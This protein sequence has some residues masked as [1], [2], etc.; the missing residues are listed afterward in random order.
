ME[1]NKYYI[2]EISEFFVGFEYEMLNKDIWEQHTIS[3]S[4]TLSYF[5]FRLQ[6]STLNS[7][8]R[9]KYLDKYDIESLGWIDISNEDSPFDLK[10]YTYKTY[11]LIRDNLTNIKIFKMDLNKDFRGELFQGTIK[12][13]SE[14]RKLLKQIG[15][16]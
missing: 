7:V 5:M 16:E 9:V 3:D 6:Q 1:D 13:I 11:I 12:N 8:V 4:E 10:S 2:P 14:L 15:I